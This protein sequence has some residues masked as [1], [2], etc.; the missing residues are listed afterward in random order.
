[1]T[2]L[3][4]RTLFPLTHPQS[5]IWYTENKYPQSN[6]NLIVVSS[7][8]E[9]AVRFDVMEQAIRKFIR[10]QDS[11]RIRLIRVD[12][13][14]RQ[15]MD[16]ETDLQPVERVKL[17]RP[18]GAEDPLNA[19][20]SRKEAFQT[21]LFNCELFKIYFYEI[22]ERRGFIAKFHHLIADGWSATLFLDFIWNEYLR[23]AGQ[24]AREDQLPQVPQVPQALPVPVPQGSYLRYMENERSY[25]NSSR[26]AKSSSF[27]LNTFTPLPEKLPAPNDSTAARRSYFLLSDEQ[28]AGIRKFIQDSDISIPSFFM[29]VL[30]MYLS[31]V[32]QCTDLVLGTPVFNRSSREERAMFGMCTSTMPVRLTSDAD[33]PLR[34]LFSSVHKELRRCYFHQ[35]YPYD[36]LI[37]SLKKHH[38][39]LNQLFEY[40]LNFLNYRFIPELN[41][42]PIVTN[43]HHTGEQTESLSLLIGE[44]HERKLM[45]MYDYKTEMFT[46]QDIILMNERIQFLIDQLLKNG[47]L[48]LKD[49]DIMHKEERKRILHEFNETSKP[50]PSDQTVVSLFEQQVERSPDATAA[51]YQ[52]RKLTY[53]EL[54]AR[55]NRLAWR[56]RAEGVRAGSVVALMAH[57][58]LDMLA[59]LYGIL[60]AGAAYLPLDPGYPQERI[61]YM[62]EDSG[63]GLLLG[64]SESLDGVPFEG[65]VLDLS[66]EADDGLPEGNPEP[67]GGPGDLAYVIY[68]SGSTGRPKGVMIEHQALVNRLAWM[69]NRYPLQAHD[70]ILQKTPLSFDVSVWELFWWSLY[71]AGVCLLEP[72]GEKDPAVFTQTIAAHGVTVLHFVPSMLNAWLGHMETAGNPAE[73]AGVKRV[74]ASG[75]ALNKRQVDRFY[76]IAGEHGTALVNLYGP[77]EAAVD[78]TYF[79]C[80]PGLERIPIGRP[81]DNTRLYIVDEDRQLRPI[82]VPGE[83]CIA[84]AGLARGYLGRPELTQEKFVENPFEPGER[85]YRTGD[86]ARWLPDGNVE[87]IGRMDHQVKIRGYRIE[88]GEV[89]AQLLQVEDVTEAVV[90][91]REDKLGQKQLCAYYVAARELA[92]SEIR[93]RL[94]AVL[95]G[96]MIPAH[97]I[98]L[99]G[100]PLTVNGKLD[101]KALPAPGGRRQ[102]GVEYAA[103]RTPEEHL[104]VSVWKSVLGAERIGVKDSFFELGGDSIQSLQVISKLYPAGYKLDMKDVFHYPTL[105]QM[106]TRLTPVT[107]LADQGEVTGGIRPTP[108]IARFME[109]AKESIHHYNQSLFLFRPERF[110][111]AALRLTLQGIVTHHDALR[112]VMRQDEQENT[113]WIRGAEEGELFQLEVIDCRGEASAGNKIEAKAAELQSGFNL[114]TGPLMKVALFRCGDGD[115]LLI[116]IHHLAVDGYS[117]RIVLEDLAKGYQQALL[118]AEPV[119]PLKT[120]SF[121]VWSEQL[122]AYAD[123]EALLEEL[124]YWQEVDRTPVRALPKDMQQAV[125]R[126]QD[127]EALTVEWSVEETELLLKEAQRAY[128]TEVNDLLLTALGIAVGEWS[129]HQEVM[130]DLEGHGREAHLQDTDISRTVGWFTSIFPVVLRNEAELP[131]SQRIKRVKEQLRGVPGKGVG[132]GLLRYLST[133][134]EQRGLCAKPEISFNYLGQF[135]PN[136]QHHGLNLKVSP[137]ASG[138]LVGGN[139][140]RPYTLDFQG[141]VASGRLSLTISYSS[142]QYRSTSIGRLA[143]RLQTALREVLDHCMEREYSELTP[144]DLLIKDM[145]LEEVEEL[146]VQ[147]RPYGELENVYPLTPMQKGMLFHSLLGGQPGAYVEQVS[148]QLQGSLDIE[149]LRRSWMAV[150]RRHDVLRTN[151]YGSGREEPVQLVFRAK[152]IPFQY[153][154]IRGMNVIERAAYAE[155]WIARDRARGFELSR[156]PLMRVAVLRK[157]D[158]AYQILWSH[159]HILLDG[160]CLPLIFREL[161]SLYACYLKG[162]EPELP[163]AVPYRRYLS[164]LEQRDVEAAEKYWMAYLEGYEG[165]SSL[166][167]RAA[168]EAQQS[169]YDPKVYKTGFGRDLTERMNGTARRNGVTL[170][171]LL[172]TAWAVLLQMYTGRQ[173]VVFGSVVSGRPPEI[174]GIEAIVGLCIN[175]IP[176]RIVCRMEESFSEAMRRTQEQA[177][178]SEAYHAYPL[179]EIQAKLPQNGALIDH[180]LVFENYPLAEGLSS[181]GEQLGIHLTFGDIT[182]REQTHYDLNLIVLPGEELTVQFQ[183]NGKVYEEQAIERMAGHLVHILEQVVD[184]PH[185]AVGDLELMTQQEILLQQES[186]NN[187]AAPYPKEKTVHALF[188]EQAEKTPDALAVVSDGEAATYRELNEQSNRLARFLQSKGVGRESIVA[189]QMPRSLRY[190]QFVLGVLKAGGAILPIDPSTPAERIRH[191]LSDSSPALVVTDLPLTE[192]IL[193]DAE[194]VTAEEAISRSRTLPSTDLAIGASSGSGDALYVIYT[195]G[196]TGT[197]KGVLIEHRT[198]INL[199]QWQQDS[200]PVEAGASKVLQF[201]AMGFDVCYQE[202]FTA[203]LGGAE[204]HLVGEDRKRQPEEFAQ[205]VVSSGVDIVFLPTA[206]LKFLASE[207]RYL[208][209]LSQGR[210]RHIVVA[211][212][213]LVIHP[214]LRAYLLEHEVTLHNHYGPSETHVV[215]SHRMQGKDPLLPNLPPIGK[216]IANTSLFIIGRNGRLLPAGAAGELCIGGAGLARGYVN[217]AELT[218]EKFVNH[219]LQAGERVYRTGDLARWLP[220]G[221][222]E[223]LGRMDHQV[224]IRGYRIELG[225]VEARLLDIAPVTE[226][227]VLALDDEEGAKYL[228]AYIVAESGLTSGDIRSAL[229]EELP[230]YMIPSFIVQ[231][232][233]LP[234]TV[235]G[236]VDRRALPKPDQAVRSEA[237]YVAPRNET[238]DRL[239]DIWKSV[240]KRQDIGVRDNFFELGGHSLSAASLTGRIYKELNRDLPLREVFRYPTIEG[241][242]R[243]I[244]AASRSGYTPI[245]LVEERAYYPVSSAQKRIYLVSHLN[246]GGLSYNMPG[247]LQIDGPLDRPRVQEAFQ[248]MIA[249]HESLRTGF[250]MLDGDVIARIYEAVPFSVELVPFMEQAEPDLLRSFIRPFDLSQAP[251]LRARLIE[252]GPE[253]HLLLFDM[254]HIVSDGVSL[255]LLAREFIR[256]YQGQELP[257]LSV[258]YKD[259]AVWQQELTARPAMQPHRQYWMD[260]FQDGV[261]VLEL[262]TD[263]PRPPAQSFEGDTV[264]FRIGQ[265]LLQGLQELARETGTTLYMTLLAAFNVL[266]FKYSGQTDIVVGSPVAGRE[267]PDVDPLIGMFVNTLA[268]R[269]YP[270]GGKTFRA[271]LTEVGEGAVEAFVH[272]AYP[273]EELVEQVQVHRDLSR[274]PLFDVMLVLQ[275]MEQDE[276][277]APGLT[278]SSY[279]IDSRVVKFDLT[280]TL[281]EE[282]GG[283]QASLAYAVRLLER[284]TAER[285]ATHFLEVLGSVVSEPDRLLGDIQ[286]MTAPERHDILEGFNRTETGYPREHTIHALFEEQAARTPDAMAVTDEE[287]RQ[288][289]YAE[290]N[291]RA[292]QVANKL[293]GCGVLADTIVGLLTER[294]LDMM[295]GIFGILKAGGAYLPVDPSYP[296]E[297]IRYFLED[298]GTKVLLTGQPAAQEAAAFDGIVLDLKG[299]AFSDEPMDNLV[300]VSGPDHLAYVIYTS[301]STGRPKGVMIE[302]H[303]VINRLHW[304][305]KEYGLGEGDLVLQKTPISFDVSVWELFWWSW[306]GAGLCL[307]PPG[308]EKDPAVIAAVIARQRVTTMHFVPPMLGA[309]LDY[310]EAHPDE[311]PGMASLKQV[312]T[313]GQAL[314][315]QLVDR[316]Y[317][318]L[319]EDGIRLMNLY[320]PTEATVDVTSFDCIPG[321]ERIPIGKPIDNIRLYVV[322]ENLHLL[323]VGI[324]GEL[325]IA[326]VGLARG[327]LGRP[328]LTAEKFVDDPFA[329]EGR[330]YRTG[331]TAR[332][333]PDGNVEYLGRMDHQVKIRGNRIEPG[334]IEEALLRHE[335]V[336]EAAVIDRTDETGTSYLVAY[337]AVQGEIAGYELRAHL[338]RSLPQYMIPAYFVTMERLPLTPNG[339][340]DRRALPVPDTAAAREEA[341]AAPQS[342][343]E[344][345]LAALW[346][347][348]LGAE[349]V[350]TRDNFFQMG[351]DSIKLIRLSNRIHQVFG[352]EARLK[353]L[354]AFQTIGEFAR[355][356][357]EPGTGSE[358]EEMELA[359]GL[360]LIGALQDRLRDEPAM[361]QYLL[362]GIEDFYPLSKIQQ[363]MVYYSKLKPSEPIYHDQFFFTARIHRL[364]AGWIRQTTLTLMGRHAILRTVFDTVR[365]SEPLQLVYKQVE[366]D[367]S[368]EDIMH[369]S[370]EAQRQYIEER[371][372]ADLADKYLTDDRLLWRLRV[373]RIGAEEAVILLSFHHAALDGWSVAVFQQEFMELYNR[374]AEAQQDALPES[375]ELPPLRTSYKEYVA[376]NAYK[377]ADEKT[378][379]FWRAFLAGSTRGKLPFNMARK[380]RSSTAPSAMINKTVDPGLV[381]RLEEGARA[382]GCTVRDLCLGAHLYLLRIITTEAD[383]VTGVVSHDRPA[384]DDGDRMLGC[385]LNSL[386]MRMRIGKRESK[387][388]LLRQVADTLYRMKAHEVFLS[389]IARMTGERSDPSLNPIFD[390]L[391]NYTDFHVLNFRAAGDGIRPEEAAGLEMESAEMTNT[392]LDVEVHR[393]SGHMNVQIKYAPSYFYDQDMETV[394][395]LYVRILEELCDETDPVLGSG[396]LILTEKETRMLREWNAPVHELAAACTEGKTLHGLFEEQAARTPDHAAVRHG[397]RTLTYA[398]LEAEANRLARH[399]ARQG[400][401]SGDHV[402][403]VAG[404]GAGMITG[405]LAILKAG[406]AY[407]PVDPEYPPG[408]KAYILQNAEAA[409]VLADRAYPDLAHE[410]VILMHDEG[411][412]GESAEPLR[413]AKDSGELAYIIY[414]SGSTGTPKGVMIEHRSAVN[415]VSWVNRRFAV[416]GEDRLL[417]IT[418]MCFDLSVYDI[419]GMLAAGGTVVVA[420]REEVLEPGAL[421]RLMEAENVTFWDSVPTTMNHFIHHLEEGPAAASLP[422]GLRLVFLSGDWI[423][424]TLPG[425]IRQLFP[426]AEVISL[427]GATEGTV[428]SNYY[429]V[430][431][432]SLDQS[433]IPYGRPIGG[434]AFYILDDDREPVPWGVV[435]ELYIGGV[436]VARGYMNDEAKTAAAFLPDPFLPGGGRMYKTG[437]LGR[438]LPDG[439]MEFLGRKDHQVKI[440][441]Y[442]VELGEIDSRLARH[443]GIREAVVVD[444]LDGREQR[445]LCAYIVPSGGLTVAAVRDYLAAELPS[446]MVPGAYVFLEGLPL[447]ANGKVDRKALPEPGEL[448]DSGFSHTAPRTPE[449]LKLAEIWQEVLGLKRVGVYEDFFE[450]GGDSLGAA[451]MAGRIQ[452]EMGVALPLREIFRL[453]TI[454]KL[455]VLVQGSQ[456]AGYAGIPVLPNRE[457][458]RASAAQEWI[459]TLSTMS[460][461]GDVYNMPHVLEVSGQLDEERLRST[462]LKLMERHETLRTGFDIREEDVV[463]RIYPEVPFEIERLPW[464]PDQREMQ[465]AISRFIRPF[466]LSKPPLLRVGLA[467]QQNGKHLMIVDMHHIISDGVSMQI[468]MRDFL[469][470]YAGE[471]LAP[472][473]VQYKDY[474]AWQRERMQSEPYLQQKAYW[475]KSLSGELRGIELPIAYPRPSLRSY[476]GARY[477]FEVDSEVS[478]GLRRLAASSGSTMFM[479]LMAAYTVLLSHY[480]GSEDIILGTHVAGRISGE[481]EGMIGMFV[482]T[483]ALRNYPRKELTFREYVHEVREN[484]LEAFENQEYPFPEL[485]ENLGIRRDPGRNPL[486]DFV[487]AFAEMESGNAELDGIS[488]RPYAME[489]TTTKF[490]LSLTMELDD[491]G[492]RGAFEYSTALFPM[493]SIEALTRDYLELLAGIAS[494]PDR[495][496]ADLQVTRFQK[497]TVLPLETIELIF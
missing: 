394:F 382:Y 376:L 28:D 255:N 293:R 266:L 405:M 301:G 355:C 323:P 307:L 44:R 232:G 296:A 254:H 287:G 305:Q 320:G 155:D 290:L 106:S 353:D 304:M 349:Q 312:F 230:A 380:P 324:P 130:V 172:Q 97:L 174:P 239:A 443:P 10:S 475:L 429:P 163:P 354:Y 360:G 263:Y 201:A 200:I 272:Q 42:I 71:G 346:S 115:H 169:A 325:C 477:S 447:N 399:L 60:K 460:G 342:S 390:T 400:V 440:R 118:G 192:A 191:M 252:K 61:R 112:M 122:A 152:E 384:V 8:T 181:L 281:T 253:Q 144:S 229:A 351:G 91:A 397:G 371:R 180:I 269:N 381:R 1:M 333:L 267:H 196:S 193:G 227:V 345:K 280:L 59:G 490:D 136:L 151:F 140:E 432:V 486:F 308:G 203:L 259:Y 402:A 473:P 148:L 478:D 277:S 328:E 157:E 45:V 289:T 82:G 212:E 88:L 494:N 347:E 271:F 387:Q 385:F 244:D 228:C 188:R 150:T 358:P 391:F 369:L 373:F 431:E 206:Y 430:G 241:M 224:K 467:D 466:D 482:G 258:Q 286:I 189:L 492:L 350:G 480:S 46:E 261:P 27:W 340:L 231:L 295:A 126:V 265:G 48:R 329:G 322:D 275:N 171:T 127:S 132:Y 370:V 464:K 476:E 330:M 448:Q 190:I 66:D 13:E 414:T 159:H 240:L 55:A 365:F 303:S 420:E 107:R 76:R 426:L 56:L 392:L 226:A 422:A 30:Y 336:R 344:W 352:T 491:T 195:S 101:R 41:G 234:L 463:Q 257:P 462:F 80:T 138:S 103:P 247:A 147:Y 472:L 375:F 65:I 161:F 50:Y 411:I 364:D 202:I 49:I 58:S 318:C 199:L 235:N 213:Q 84:G 395:T 237:V 29:T 450:I 446:Y 458:Y 341:Y 424:V 284:K 291:A 221:S 21:D 131:L 378:A 205:A 302:H 314:P 452:K 154:D 442:R 367:L 146:T 81:I 326:G 22:G 67:A 359:R 437:D 90:I 481:L 19:L 121:Q 104:L 25:M 24:A 111:E 456:Q 366:P 406:A 162:N 153:E 418:S 321:L 95:P 217:R 57:R 116:V 256:C 204:L 474:A 451:S 194:A 396:A 273:F 78:V 348:V 92:S 417:F 459:Y 356:M 439:N 285:M 89:E 62:L 404:R 457:Y 425:R 120:D 334:E 216:P 149:L 220:D 5:R 79:D 2:R 175:T 102:T 34:R 38:P 72:G 31:H 64:S 319:G 23:T 6:L 166:P 93:S 14:I 114:S 143:E 113:L 53:R 453:P 77:T 236:K 408:R 313:S 315:K 389:D 52:D 470:L 207:K 283:L 327:Y 70:V 335:R 164:W 317:A 379:E 211:G 403:L 35:K 117:W 197:P 156:D 86:L 158:A 441:G 47:E 170:N 362:Q 398:R 309:F 331:D 11:L 96:H 270:E 177:L 133:D 449:E 186:F 479:T 129:G 427:G 26:Q 338:A 493:K 264:I 119:L 276:L 292:N 145:T 238:E 108:V 32:Q 36:L 9:Q 173:D 279:E 110:E 187:T 246:G 488:V 185:R 469:R 412:A 184:D 260:R 12:G 316:F 262:P 17:D 39:E 167:K 134:K 182:V 496:L 445:Y 128:N 433:S 489:H 243:V 495:H 454:E 208:K 413:L 278:L 4:R 74:F 337:V 160:W 15:Y 268:L 179:Y 7:E 210:V 383:I 332:W 471:E 219:P 225:E 497:K 282:R 299:D 372:H 54:N 135:D 137:Y 343:T 125:P 218:A 249:R 3:K 222:L 141:A 483:L 410:R 423:P 485:V 176:V 419:F 436:G 87:Y 83:L 43:W 142:K 214:N 357:E 73:L 374:L 139:A 407:V 298:S 363:S 123:S 40:G 37:P 165:S 69:Q 215:T 434:N 18:A 368:V 421:L 428:W 444:R 33:V 168:D 16:E 393:S 105:E 198:L 51:V 306:Y 63:A 401:R 300:P 311:V 487:F 248:R 465:V 100:M 310:L 124:I 209:A 288:L 339:K 20:A 68:T 99:P 274:S 251:L 75:E 416:G 361:Q 386:P 242:A 297:R 109:L 183:F 438:L 94:S 98:Q 178:G 245:P 455:A 435:G 377:Q 484:T 85:M 468:V 415:L 250:E 223:Y 294:S 233:S 388:G 461:E 409:A